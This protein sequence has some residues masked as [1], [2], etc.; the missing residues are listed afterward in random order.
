[1]LA[2][3]IAT[4]ADTPLL[5]ELNHQL[6]R[7]EGHRNRMT[8][9]DLET[10]MRG[11]LRDGYT[12]VIFERGKE[13]VAYA[14]FRPDGDGMYL[15]QL[16]VTRQARRSGIGR[17]AVARLREMWPQDIRITVDVL[18]HNP[19]AQSF[20]RSLGFADYSLTLELNN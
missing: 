15:R 9:P 20:W 3:R 4:E 16:F 10:R 14:L 13:V 17:E 5:A 6:I 1:M 7:D 18:I 2:L 8:V 19:I 12:A 11:F